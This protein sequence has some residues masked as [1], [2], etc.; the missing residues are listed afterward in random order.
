MP[1]GYRLELPPDAVDAAAVRAARSPGASPA[2]ARH[3]HGAQRCS[4]E[5]LALWRGAALADVA[6]DAVRRGRIARL[7]ELRLAAAEERAPAALLGGAEPAVLVA[8]LA[9]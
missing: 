7:D 3:P 1:G 6:D 2:G 9:A 5:A 8:E 4:G